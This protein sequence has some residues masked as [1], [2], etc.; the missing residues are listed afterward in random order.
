MAPPKGKSGWLFVP[1]ALEK[2]S[3]K[4]GNGFCTCMTGVMGPRE[5]A[6]RFDPGRTLSSC[7]HIYMCSYYCDRGDSDCGGTVACMY[8]SCWTGLCCMAAALHSCFISY[9]LF[10]PFFPSY[11]RG[12][13][14]WELEL[15][16]HGESSQSLGDLQRIMLGVATSVV[17]LAGGAGELSR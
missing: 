10:L 14:A 16:L 13:F 5:T 6:V 9:G 8:I 3:K 11:S 1:R 7:G 12:L 17:V 2:G 4:S 15:Y